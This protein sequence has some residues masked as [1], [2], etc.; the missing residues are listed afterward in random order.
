MKGLIYM[1]KRILGLALALIMMLSS[2]PSMAYSVRDAYADFV[3]EYSGFV[4]TLMAAGDGTV[5]EGLLID[6]LGELQDYLA[7]IN[8]YAEEITEENLQDNLVEAVQSILTTSTYAPLY[9]AIYTAYPSAVKAAIKGE[10]SPDLMPI[11][12]TIKSM[13]FQY[14]MLED[15]DHSDSGDLKIV[16]ISELG[17]VSVDQGDTVRLPASVDAKSETGVNTRL[18]IEWEGTPDTSKAGTFS[19]AGKIRVPAGYA[20]DKGLSEDVSVK[21]I[22]AKKDSGGTSSGGTSSG[23][24]GGG[25]GG[26]IGG[27]SG[28][29]SNVTQTVTHKNKFSDVPSDTTEAGKAIYAL[30]DIGVINGYGDG[31]FLPG[32][33]IKRSEFTT[34][35]VTALGLYNKDATTS[36]ADVAAGAWYHS[37]VASAVYN[38][39]IKG[40]EDNTFRPENQITRAEV[41]T[42]IW[43]A[44]NNNKALTATAAQTPYADDG[45]IP[46]Y[47]RD[48]VYALAANGIV[49]AADN[50]IKAEAPATREQCAVML[51]NA[52]VKLGKI[53]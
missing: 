51:Y 45:A 15:V 33:N 18:P 23:G 27:G 13:I 5:S 3:S 21:I 11:Y 48:Y 53:K 47:A 16:E 17:D 24:T 20:L 41:M 2:A 34:M 6:F 1:K 37:Y 49:K 9:S 8:K 46:A 7:Y 35:V 29:D 36:F 28:N 25:V 32:N 26:G 31:T 22:V 40:Y 38:D 43:R 14:H 39:L 50:M 30:N 10:I 44:L 42:V 52:L 4:D 19:F 12:D